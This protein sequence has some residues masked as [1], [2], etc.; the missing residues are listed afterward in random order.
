MNVEDI[1][2]GDKV[3]ITDQNATYKVRVTEVDDEWIDG[4]YRP[5]ASGPQILEGSWIK[6]NITKVETLPGHVDL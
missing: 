4:D 2:A 5:F 6:A 3:A 1:K